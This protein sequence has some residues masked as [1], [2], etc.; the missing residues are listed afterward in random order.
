MYIKIDV[1]MATEFW[2]SSFSIFAFFI[3]KRRLSISL[4]QNNFKYIAL[5]FTLFKGHKCNRLFE[6]TPKKVLMGAREN[7]L[8]KLRISQNEIF[9]T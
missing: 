8:Q 3:K 5:I 1:T 9:N 2:Q 4:Y 7:K 6:V